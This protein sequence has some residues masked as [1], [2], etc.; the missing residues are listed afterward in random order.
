MAHPAL[1]RC[2]CSNLLLVDKQSRQLPL[3][4]PLHSHQPHLPELLLHNFSLQPP[5]LRDEAITS[6]TTLATSQK[7]FWHCSQ[8]E[9]GSGDR[10]EDLINQ[11][12]R[13]KPPRLTDV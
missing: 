9:D 12:I 3:A 8:A 7:R 2:H 5:L 13:P 4:L 1:P 11:L 10:L 6:T